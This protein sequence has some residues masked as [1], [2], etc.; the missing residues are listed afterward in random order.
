[1]WRPRD[2]PVGRLPRPARRPRRVPCPFG[3]EPAEQ[4]DMNVPVPDDVA[5]I[6]ADFALGRDAAFIAPHPFKCGGLIMSAMRKSAAARD[7]APSA[8]IWTR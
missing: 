4:P 8:L 3:V 6:A 2:P 1:M 5:I 7:R